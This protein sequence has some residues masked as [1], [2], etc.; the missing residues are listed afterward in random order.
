MPSQKPAHPVDSLSSEKTAQH[1]RNWQISPGGC[2]VCTSG[3]VIHTYY[4]K[5]SKKNV[6]KTKKIKNWSVTR[7]CYGFNM[8]NCVQ[9][10][11]TKHL[12]PE[13]E[14]QASSGPVSLASWATWTVAPPAA[15]TSQAQPEATLISLI[16]KKSWRLDVNSWRGHNRFIN[17]NAELWKKNQT[18]SIWLY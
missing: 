11:P 4:K 1:R 6:L 5:K 18:C 10:C 17:L 7:C 13:T 3:T 16:F 9:Q 12:Y 2:I 15:Q 8:F 14:Q